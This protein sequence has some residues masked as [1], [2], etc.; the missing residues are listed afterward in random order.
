MSRDSIWSGIRQGL[1]DRLLRRALI[2]A[3]LA[4]VILFGGLVYYW[5]HNTSA[6]ESLPASYG[7][8]RG[9][10][11]DSVNGTGVLADMFELSG[12]QVRTAD[13]LSPRLDKDADV[14]VW[15]PNDFEP[16]TKKQREFLERW[17]SGGTRRTLVYVG[18]DY[19]AA[20]DYW[21][22][23]QS[24]A[25]PQDAKRLTELADHAES[26]HAA[27]RASMPT[28]EFARWFTV[29]SGGQ[30]Q[31]AKK[32]SGPWSQGIDESKARISFRGRLDI[33]A[34]ADATGK[35][36]PLPP[37]ETE[38]LLVGDRQ[39]LAFRASDFAWSSGQV[40][41]V[42]NGSFLLNY[43]LVNREHRKLAGRLIDECSGGRSVVFLESGPGGPE[44]LDKEAPTTGGLAMLRIW[45]LNAIV[46]H[47]TIFGLVYCLA[48][49]PVFGR[50]KEIPGEN[51]ADF[52]RHVT[53]LGQLLARTKDLGYAQS[54]L[55]QYQQQ[56]RR[57]S[58][59]S[60]GK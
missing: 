58:G 52:G 37:D 15:F 54:R 2:V 59:A 60:H 51:P 40:I 39:T 48:R 43:P 42:A 9:R 46:I 22:A 28:Q 24:G 33:P 47:L 36:D 16:P 56:S 30:E 35:D 32:L 49:W 21:K 26:A 25:A 41:V 27:G 1:Q 50:P 44:V 4:A 7:Q 10:G 23:V 13:R 3:G 11:A 53:A 14:I 17:L 57:G 55:A 38:P 45:P 29:K 31:V 12:F 19:N 20:P 8:R 5:Q 34:T 6:G 18:R